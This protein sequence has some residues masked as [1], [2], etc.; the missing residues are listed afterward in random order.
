M[1]AT[2]PGIPEW[3]ELRAAIQQAGALQATQSTHLDEDDIGVAV[4]FAQN[5]D[6]ACRLPAAVRQ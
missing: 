3:C 2:E 5:L 4:L 6:S 1:F